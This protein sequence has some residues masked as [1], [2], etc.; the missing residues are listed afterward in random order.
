M[1]CKRTSS[2]PFHFILLFFLFSCTQ[3]PQKK[4]V[5]LYHHYC[6]SCHL[7]PKIEE[8][9]KHIWEHSV[10]PDMLSRMKIAEMY[11]DPVQMKADFRPEIKLAD[12]LALKKYISSLAPEELRQTPLPQQKILSNFITKKLRLDKEGGG[13]YTFFDYKE[14]ENVLIVGKLDGSL[15]R[16]NFQTGTT[17]Q[18][19]QGET[20]ITWYNRNNQFEIITEVGILDPSELV[21][22]KVVLKEGND[23]VALSNSFHRPVH[24]LVED[25][26]GDGVEEM[27]V[28]EFGNEKGKLSLLVKKIVSI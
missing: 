11:E 23:T 24:N 27:V 14:V 8:L 17:A 13:G 18:I 9:P 3:E 12:W 16:H 21:H 4:E 28:S 25:L 6:S 1:N 7:L 5:T 22:G 15:K 2:K 26:N 10:L 19:Y 20:P